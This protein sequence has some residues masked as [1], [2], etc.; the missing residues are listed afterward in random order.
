E[1]ITRIRVQK[2]RLH[3]SD[4][5]NGYETIYLDDFIL[6]GESMS[7]DFG[8]KSTQL[9][10]SEYHI[11]GLLMGRPGAARTRDELLMA[12]YAQDIYLCDRVID[13]YIKRIRTKIRDLTESKTQYIRTFYGVGYGW[14]SL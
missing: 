14:S 9:T 1:L 6:N 10:L 2:R 13:N 5:T 8:D 7:L 4:R 3:Q 11:L 12:V